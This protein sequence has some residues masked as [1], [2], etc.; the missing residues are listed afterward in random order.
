[1]RSETVGLQD[2]ED[3]VTGD[4]LDLGDTVRV[5]EDDTDLG[6]GQTLAS[7]LEDVLLDLLSGDLEPSGS[8]ALVRESRTG[9]NEQRKVLSVGS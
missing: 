4:G 2:T 7:E 5:T 6:R 1:M 8:R 3:L 9:L